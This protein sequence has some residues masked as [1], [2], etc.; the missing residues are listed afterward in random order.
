MSNDPSVETVKVLQQHDSHYNNYYVTKQAV[1]TTVSLN[2]GGG[3]PAARR[4]L[5][6]KV[7]KEEVVAKKRASTMDSLRLSSDEHRQH[8]AGGRQSTR[9]S[10]LREAKQLGVLRRNRSPRELYS[11]DDTKE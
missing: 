9:A 7:L 1:P 2:I 6:L 3:S 4:L 5:G 8:T 11:D 10:E